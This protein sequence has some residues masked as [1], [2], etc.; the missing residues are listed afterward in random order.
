MGE[1][2]TLL[3]VLRFLTII[4]LLRVFLS[5]DKHHLI[6][7]NFARDLHVP[8]VPTYY[9]Q[10]WLRKMILD[11]DQWSLCR[12]IVQG[13]LPTATWSLFTVHISLW[14]SAP[15]PPSRWTA[16]ESVEWRVTSCGMEWKIATCRVS[17]SLSVSPLDAFQ[18]V[19]KGNQR[20]PAIESAF[21][22][23]LTPS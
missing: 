14:H 17:I 10:P 2:R 9:F 11:S 7:A 12:V 19:T 3:F 23:W 5:H 18:P 6:H 1:R 13:L 4:T 8:L 21:S 22:E 15:P 20:D 16:G